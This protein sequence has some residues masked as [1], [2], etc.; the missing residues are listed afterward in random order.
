MIQRMWRRYYIC[1]I[2]IVVITTGT[3]G[4]TF[5]ASSN[6]HNI[7]PGN[8]M[9]VSLLPSCSGN[10]VNGDLGSTWADARTEADVKKMS[11]CKDRSWCE[12][13]GRARRSICS[14]NGKGGASKERLWDIWS[15]NYWNSNMNCWRWGST[16]RT[17]LMEIA[18]WVWGYR[19]SA[20][21][22]SKSIRISAGLPLWKLVDDCHQRRI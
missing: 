18:F 9:L 5:I 19:C 20:W 14:S 6:Y 22:C 21:G 11:R 15:I 16:W 2:A 12:K 13:T 7:V 3:I 1:V 8:R 17:N 4:S 10:E